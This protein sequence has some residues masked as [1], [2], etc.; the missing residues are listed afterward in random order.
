MPVLTRSNS[1]NNLTFAVP[2]TAKFKKHAQ[3][4][5]NL[6]SHPEKQ[7]Q[8]YYNT[9]AVLAV[10]F[11]CQC[12][13]IDTNIEDSSSFDQL[14]IIL[15]NTAELD[16]PKLGKIECRPF[17]PKDRTVTIPK[18]TWTN[19]IGYVAVKIDEAHRQAIITGFMPI[20]TQEK[21]E[22]EKW[23]AI[24]HFRDYVNQLKDSPKQTQL[25]QWLE[26]ILE[27]EPGWENIADTIINPLDLQPAWNSRQIPIKAN[28]NSLRKQPIKQTKQLEL[29]EHQIGL[30]IGF[31]SSDS[32][33]LDICIA[34]YSAGNEIYL[35][36]D[37]E[38]AIIDAAGVS[39]LHDIARENQQM[40]MEFGVMSGENFML[41]LTLGVLSI[42]ETICV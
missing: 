17:L 10:N 31:I 7:Q 16:L 15:Y 11:Y 22:I 42:T 23:R 4:L 32:P 21:L 28:N 33:E 34:V 36:D 37:L 24:A 13:E 2:L 20:I 29:G 26:N 3:Q 41:K 5:S 19:R 39:I 35:P 27:P 8:I 40:Q 12:L 25:S 18:E 9:L 6:V 14:K 1:K 38:L 30:C